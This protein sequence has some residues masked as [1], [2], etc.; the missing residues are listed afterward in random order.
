MTD[1]FYA[2]VTLMGALARL[3]TPQLLV[4]GQTDAAVLLV[5]SAALG[6]GWL[7]WLLGGPVA[8]GAAAAFLALSVAVPLAPALT[9]P[10]LDFT[11]AVPLVFA[12]AASTFCP[13]LVLGIWWRGLTSPGAISGVLVGGGLSGAALAVSMLA[14]VPPGWFG[15]LLHRPAAVT[16]PAAF[17]TMVVVSRLTRADIPADVDHALLRLHAPEQ[18]GPST[19]GPRRPRS[20]PSRDRGVTWADRAVMVV[21]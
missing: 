5:P 21:G 14:T 1:V 3:H 12:V 18:L 6:Q 8:A 10:R 20:T 13:L 16:V 11:V 2:L 9:V 4:S 7:G 15:V 19:E 17:L